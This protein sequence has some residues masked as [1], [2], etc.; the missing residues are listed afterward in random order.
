MQSIHASI[1]D[2]S[3]IIPLSEWKIIKNKLEKTPALEIIEEDRMQALE[4]L[5]GLGKDIWDDV[6]PV[7]YQKKERESW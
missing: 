7:E 2:D 3:V 5:I 4:S 1:I 6:D